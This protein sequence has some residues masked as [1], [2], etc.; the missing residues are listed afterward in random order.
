MSRDNVALHNVAE[1]LPADD[2]VRLERLPPGVTEP[3][4][5][6][7][8]E[9]YRRPDGVE[10][11]FVGESAEITLSCPEG[12]CEA[13]PFW[14]P[15]QEQPGE[16]VTL[17]A[18]PTTVELSLPERVAA[19]DRDRLDDRY[20]DPTVGR[21]VLFGNP[22]VLHD[23][24]GDVRPPEPAERPDQTLLTYGTSITQGA[25]AS[26]YPM[27]YGHQTA[28]LL[29]DDHVNLGSG[30]SAFCENALADYVAGRDDWDRAVLAVSVNMI[31]A[32]FDAD[33]FGERVRYLVDTV[34]GAHSDK[35]V[36]AVT[37]YPFFADLCPDISDGD[38]WPATPSEY[39]QELRDAV[40]AADRDNLH[41][42]EGPDLLQDPGGL[43]TDLLHPMD[44]G[45][46][47]IAH[48]L[49]DRLGEL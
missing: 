12:S 33:E 45:M 15:F 14:G 37:L 25:C 36:A 11:R 7:S 1:P 26:R 18:E 31:A 10:I 29:G 6:R 9:E 46:T 42:I 20:F 24:S 19:V 38:E 22:V 5:D 16:H 43:S 39:R 34:A 2:G 48:R 49:A 32:G 8:Q 17:D 28:R 21:L 35:P 27:T 30:G 13:T 23:V 4:N 44:H 41:L 40:A 47:E 3:F